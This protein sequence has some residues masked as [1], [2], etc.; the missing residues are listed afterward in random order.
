ML[1]WAVKFQTIRHKGLKRLIED[2]DGRGLD[3][4]AVPK[5]R[6]M[7]ATL[8]GVADVEQ[9]AAFPLWRVHQLGGDQRGTWTLSVTRNHRLTFALDEEGAIVD[10]NYEDY[11]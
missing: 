5:L 1:C 4:Q 7:L 6:R 11:H 8:A 2:D 3:A 10:L 9:L